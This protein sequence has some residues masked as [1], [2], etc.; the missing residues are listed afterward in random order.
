MFLSFALAAPFLLAASSTADADADTFFETKIRPVLVESCFKC[1]GGTKT[2]HGLRVDSREA[3]LKGGTSGP[4]IVPNDAEKSLLIR[5]LRHTADD[6]KMPPGKR[7]PDAVVADLTTWIAHGARWPQTAVAAAFRPEQHWAFQPVRVSDPPPDD[8]G[9][10]ATPI[11]RFIAAGLRQQHLT[12]VGPAEPRA[13]ARRVTFDLTG[14]PPTVEETEAFVNDTSADAYPRLVERLLASSAYGERWGRHW[15]DIARYA[16]T[17]G[18]NADYPVPEAHL[19][20]DYVIDAFNNDKPYDQFVREQLAG[21]ILAKDGPAEKYADRVVATGFLALSRRYATAPYELWHLTLED[22]IDTTGKAFLGLTLRCAR[23]HDH[24][25]DPITQTDYYALYGFFASTQFP[26]AGAEELAS[27]GF[28]RRHFQPL[29]T[30]TQAAP[31]FAG[32]E[33]RLS[34]VNGALAAAEEGFDQS[35]IKSL[36]AEI[37][38]LSRPGLPLD[39]PGAYAVEDGPATDVAVQMRG[40][41]DTTGPVVHRD[42]PKFLRKTPLV[43]PPTGSGREALARWVASPE[44]PLTARVMANR[45]WQF[46]FGKG[47]VTTPSNF[48]TRGEPPTHPQ[49]LDW[50]ADRFVRSGW[51]IKSLHR[52]M[53][54]SKTYQLTSTADAKDAAID[55]GNRWYWRHDRQRLDAEETR[56]AVLAVAGTLDRQRPGPH[57]FPPLE[58]WAWT[59]HNAFKEVYPS[60][61]RSVY[62]MTQRLQRHPFLGLFD[63]PD[64]NTTTDQRTSSTVPPQALFLMNNPFVAEQAEAFARRLLTETP[65]TDPCIDRAV[66]LVWGRPPTSAEHERA[67]HFFDACRAK[68]TAAGVAAELREFQVRSSFARVLFCANEFVYVD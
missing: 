51:S 30:P 20:R 45:I 65:D 56:D 13:L 10:A 4:A 12:P 39:L 19:Y 46:H 48:G 23:C 35:K 7:L 53:L 47:L 2:S 54:L 29:L 3:L 11:D 63:G 27:M 61:H 28:N 44:N 33:R 60:M 42:A 25:F 34:E 40:E 52:D 26:W 32:H 49:L 66:H 59:Q 58:K 21:D 36:Q 68:L 57:P 1:H 8:S 14:L 17:A 5:A 18:D 15:L 43:L 24:K 31:R 37:R 67:L 41:P 64:T 62:L 6:L 16:D 22:A 9:W 55:P 50:L 38:R